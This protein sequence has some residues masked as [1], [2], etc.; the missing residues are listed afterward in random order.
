MALPAGETCHTVQYQRNYRNRDANRQIIIE[1]K[2]QVNFL[3]WYSSEMRHFR[4]YFAVRREL[5]HMPG[6]TFQLE[7]V[8]A[9]LKEDVDKMFGRAISLLF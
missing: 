3:S 8:R 1:I 4:R 7:G 2:D 9:K 5:A 6:E